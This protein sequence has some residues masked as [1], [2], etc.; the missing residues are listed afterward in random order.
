M[1]LNLG[2]KLVK[3]YIWGTAVYGAELGHFEKCV[4]NT[5]KVFKCG[6]GEGLLH[7]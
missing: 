3:C 7:P 6:A 5:L 4:G 2:K 1:D